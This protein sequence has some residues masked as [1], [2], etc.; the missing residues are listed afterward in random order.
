MLVENGKAIVETYDGENKCNS[1]FLFE[2][3]EICSC[4][5]W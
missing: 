5:F 4:V 2:G 1:C 3:P